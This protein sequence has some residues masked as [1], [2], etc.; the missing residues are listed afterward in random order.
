MLTN[1]NISE[2]SKYLFIILL[3]FLPL[4]VELEVFNSGSKVLFLT[5]PICALLS[6]LTAIYII[7]NRRKDITFTEI[8]WLS[9]AFIF[10]ILLSTLLTDS[11]KESIKFTTSLLWYFTAG[12]LVI[13]LHKFSGFQRKMAVSAF[14][15]GSSLLA[16]YVCSNY[17]RFGIFHETSYDLAKPFIEQGHTDLSIVLEATLFIGAVGFFRIRWSNIKT[18]IILLSGVF[19]F[20]AIIFYSVSKASYL[21]I[22]MSTLCFVA[23][24]VIRNRKNLVLLTYFLIPIS[25][26]FGIWKVNNY[27]HYQRVKDNPE[28]H[29]NTG[30]SK[31]DPNNPDTYKTTNLTDELFNQSTDTKKN[32]SNKER[33]NR[34]NI[35]FLMFKLHPSFGV[36]MGTFPSKYLEMIVSYPELIEE[37]TRTHDTM[38]S[39]NIYLTWLAEGGIITFISGFGLILY[40]IFWLIRDF[41][42]GKNNYLKLVL[43]MF[44][45]SFTIHGFIHDFGQNARVVIPFWI[46]LAV[47]SKQREQEKTE[48]KKTKK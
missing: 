26:I 15:L 4:S 31:Y 14:F 13:R 18:V 35:G 44:L 9:A 45:L 33:I 38:N 40:G 12:Y 5:E 48:K 19:M 6:I 1:K 20:M 7:K 27:L 2:I 46:C 36:G 28:S 25:I 39:H 21:A 47:I 43:L 11:Y 23:F 10:S 37:A 34:L 22:L 30:G 3:F 16:A 32:D 17:I 42:R 24:L 41:K 29:Y 8:D